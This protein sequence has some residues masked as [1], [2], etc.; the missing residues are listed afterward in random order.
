MLRLPLPQYTTGGQVHGRPYSNM[1]QLLRTVTGA[2]ALMRATSSLYSPCT[3]IVPSA[4]PLA[5]NSPL[6]SKLRSVT[7][8]ACSLKTLI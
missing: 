2:E 8:R 4:A 5:R 3:A 1:G 7:S 6:A